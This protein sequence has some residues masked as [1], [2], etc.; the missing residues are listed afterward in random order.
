[1]LLGDAARFIRSHL[2]KHHDL[3][4]VTRFSDP[5][6]AMLALIEKLG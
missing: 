4:R 5:V 2:H 3:Y 1:M 6:V